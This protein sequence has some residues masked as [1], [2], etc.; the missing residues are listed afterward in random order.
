MENILKNIFK[1]TALFVAMAA[2]SG[3][4]I[5]IFMMMGL[6]YKNPASTVFRAALIAS[7][8]LVFVSKIKSRNKG[9]A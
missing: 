3:L 9:K 1:Y 7:L 5:K 8:F 6:T 4:V 2:I